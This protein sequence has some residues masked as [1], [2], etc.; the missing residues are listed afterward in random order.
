MALES[1]KLICV[2]R[3]LGSTLHHARSRFSRLHDR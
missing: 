3:W 2:A 1:A